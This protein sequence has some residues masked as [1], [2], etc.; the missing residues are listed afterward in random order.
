M[1]SL[2][3]SIII[4][5]MLLVGILL[6]P[7]GTHAFYSP[8]VSQRVSKIKANVLSARQQNGTGTLNEYVQQIINEEK[9]DRLKGKATG[10]PG[11]ATV[12]FSNVF[13]DTFVDLFWQPKAK[14]PYL[15]SLDPLMMIF[16]FVPASGEYISVCLRYDIW[17]L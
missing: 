10:L 9:S 14:Y 13:A 7:S 15:A 2:K 1:Q 5:L 8:S 17:Q 3:K 16:N 4:G 6:L 11:M 12:A